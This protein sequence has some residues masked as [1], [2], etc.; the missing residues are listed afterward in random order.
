MTSVPT[1]PSPDGYISFPVTVDPNALFAQAVT[2]IM[3]QVPGWVPQ[4]G[5]LEVI[6]LEET[7]QM[8]SVVAAVAS[9]VPM[10]IFMAAGQL[11]GVLPITGTQATVTATVT[12]AD[13]AGYTIPSGLQVAF[14][15]TGNSSILFSVESA[16]TI[17]PGD[18]TGTVTLICETVGSFPNGLASATTLRLQQT[19]AQILS[20]V[21]TEV[22]SGGVDA[23]TVN[24]YINRLSA[25]LQLIAPRPI[26]PRDF[27]AMAQNVTGV[28]RALAIDGLNPGSVVTDGVTSMSS[29]NIGSATAHFETG[30][31]VGRTV[32]DSLGHVPAGAEIAVVISDT[33]A[34]LNASHAATA[35]STGDHFTFGDLTNQERCVTV[36]G[37]DDTGAALSG[38]VNTALVAYLESLREVNFLV[39]GINPT[40]TEID[41]SVTCTA[42]PGADTGAVQTA[43][44]A[45]IT[46]YLDPAT[47]SGGVLLPPQWNG[48]DTISILELAQV[49]LSTPGVLFI[50]MGDLEICLHGGSLGTAD[51]TLPGDAPLPSAGTL[52]V[53]VN[54]S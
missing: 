51:V 23:E 22:V 35:A 26:L 27:A 53:V 38:G 52:T 54:A 29:L 47:W 42:V 34:Q 11:F 45:A 30:S 20:I 12:M 7:A 4:E 40:I 46:A 21:T 14:A 25:E 36:C 9:Q 48:A 37:L 3:A 44:V 28:F 17:A 16:I 50:G 5:N 39:F 1:N 8:G 15:L 43:V 32:V 13:T 24:S 18:S 6:V 33:V 19:F 41:V 31:W 2:D 49:V 10:A